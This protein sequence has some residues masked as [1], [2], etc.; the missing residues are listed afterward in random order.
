M[1]LVKNRSYTNVLNGFMNEWMNEWMNER[2][3]E[4][5]N[6]RMNEWVNE[7]INDEWMNEWIDDRIN[8]TK[9]LDLLESGRRFFFLARGPL[10]SSPEL[11]A[12]SANS[13]AP[14]QPWEYQQ[15]PETDEPHSDNRRWGSDPDRKRNSHWNCSNDREPASQ[16]DDD[17]RTSIG[18][19]D[20][21]HVHPLLLLLLPVAVDRPNT[22][23][24]LGDGH[25]NA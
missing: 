6:E 2:M 3:N 13:E 15:E 19:S 10:S 5:T 4:R 16:P 8:W 21:R 17:Q 7:L 9:W 20:G 1:G 24:R 14:E 25:L 11:E 18:R 23:R 12:V 22:R